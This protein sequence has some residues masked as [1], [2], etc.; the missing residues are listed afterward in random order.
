MGFGY[1]VYEV[2]DLCVEVLCVVVCEVLVEDMDF[3]VL[4]DVVEMMVF[5]LFWLVKFGWWIE[6]NV[7]FYMVVFLYVFRIFVDVFI[8]V[9]VFGCMV[10][11]C[12]Y[13]FE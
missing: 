13:C 11:W 12:V 7:E 6:M 8:G 5:V 9:F 4:V 10:G 3:F 2:C 1:C